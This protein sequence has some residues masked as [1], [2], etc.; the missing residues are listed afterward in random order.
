ME[1]STA[2]WRR[3]CSD[4]NTTS[5]LVPT[6]RPNPVTMN[7]QRGAKTQNRNTPENASVV[8]GVVGGNKTSGSRQNRTPSS[9]E[10]E[11]ITPRTRSDDGDKKL[12]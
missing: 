10:T 8:G 3:R 6:P 11:T 4:L 5:S 1:S 12:T 7:K 2:L 9:I